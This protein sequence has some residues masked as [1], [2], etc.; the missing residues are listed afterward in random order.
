MASNQEAPKP[1]TPPMVEFWRSVSN[2]LSPDGQAALTVM[3]NATEVEGR[4]MFDTRDVRTRFVG[5]CKIVFGDGGTLIIASSDVRLGL[6][7]SGIEGAKSVVGQGTYRTAKD[8]TEVSVVLGVH[9]P[10]THDSVEI[11]LNMVP[12]RRDSDEM[13]GVG[14]G[15]FSDTLDYQ[16]A[17]VPGDVDAP[18]GYTKTVLPPVP[19]M[20]G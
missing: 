18:A 7:R 3:Q 1:I 17:A 14:F 8:S 13:H 15:H 4:P 6:N 5:R 12:T 2:R 10:S 16:L 19:E 9:M 20:E 11:S